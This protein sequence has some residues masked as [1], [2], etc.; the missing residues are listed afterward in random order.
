MP[1][2]NCRSNISITAAPTIIA[3]AVTKAHV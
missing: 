2:A 3:A 1:S